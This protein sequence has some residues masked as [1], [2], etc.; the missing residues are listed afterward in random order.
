MT[1]S[2]GGPK[3]VGG[4]TLVIPLAELVYMDYSDGSVGVKLYVLGYSCTCLDQTIDRLL[5]S[6]T[7]RVFH[8]YNKELSV[9]IAMDFKLFINIIWIYFKDLAIILLKYNRRRCAENQ[10]IGDKLKFN[11]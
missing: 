10:V 3:R 9:N 4:G 6:I 7:S 5:L 1:G 11:K 8:S 2:G